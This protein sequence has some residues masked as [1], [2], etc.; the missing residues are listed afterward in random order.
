MN[1]FLWIP[2]LE[3]ANWALSFWQLFAIPMALGVS[4]AYKSLH[5]TKESDFW[6]ESLIM[7]LQ[8]LMALLGFSVGLAALDI[9]VIPSL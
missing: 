4:I 3:P 2:F 6:K 7:S 5:V 1:L 8:I 9:W